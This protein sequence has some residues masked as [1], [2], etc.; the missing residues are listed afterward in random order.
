MVLGP[1]GAL[2][3]MLPVFRFGMGGVLGKGSQWMSW[4]T[5]EDLA[6]LIAVSIER[7]SLTGPVNAVAP[8]V[9]TNRLFTAALGGAVRRPA[10][11]PVPSFAVRLMFGEMASVVLES[12]R[13]VPEKA[14]GAG[15]SFQ[16]PELRAA[17]DSVLA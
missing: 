15:F 7:E 5:L 6:R 12:Q 16:H 4:I 2:A 3:K 10:V 9:V 17:L 13:A 8:G 14:L 11:L 1:G